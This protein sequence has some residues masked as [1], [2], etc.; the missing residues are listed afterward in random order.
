MICLRLQ[1]AKQ[2]IQESDG[3]GRLTTELDELIE[4]SK[5]TDACSK[6]QALQKSLQ[7]QIGLPHQSEREDQV[8]DFKNR[9]EALASPGVVQSF[10]TG[11]IGR[12]IHSL[13]TRRN[14]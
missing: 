14:T 3:W 10:Q 2:G 6:L 11:D 13:H 5:L 7:A 1:F 8:E 12:S 9:L 4:H